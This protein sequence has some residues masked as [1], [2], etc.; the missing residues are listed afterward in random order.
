MT[1]NTDSGPTSAPPSPWVMRFAPLIRAGGTALDL[2]CG[3]GRHARA[4]AAAGYRVTAVDRD[5]S[6]LGPADGIEAIQADLEDGGPWPFAERAFDGI[7]VA[8]YLHRPL[9]P[10]LVSSLAP[11]GVLIYETFAVGNEAYGRPTN[12]DFLLRDGEL[13]EAV[14]GTLSVVAF[15]AGYVERPNPAVVQRIAAVRDPEGPIPLP[16]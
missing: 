9:F 8:N 15:E 6:R 14:S 4:L 2:A 10:A 7:V 11:G 3:S 5:I 12:P 1:S 16:A 13:L